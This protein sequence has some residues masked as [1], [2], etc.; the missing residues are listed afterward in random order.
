MN[1]RKIIALVPCEF[2]KVYTIIEMERPID[3]FW[4]GQYISDVLICEKCNKTEKIL[5]SLNYRIIGSI[6]YEP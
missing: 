3:P 5:E 6:L 2:C 1:H 4:Y